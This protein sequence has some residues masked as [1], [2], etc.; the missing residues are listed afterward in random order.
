MLI[1][2]VTAIKTVILKKK[3]QRSGERRDDK[4]RDK[5]N[6]ASVPKRGNLCY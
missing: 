6:L 5:R 1:G 3:N 4:K 2:G